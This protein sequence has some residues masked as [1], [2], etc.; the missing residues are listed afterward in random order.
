ML[1]RDIMTRDV[2]T[3]QPGTPVEEIARLLLAHRISGVPVVDPDGRVVG[4]VTEA[5]LIVRERPEGARSRWLRWFG[6]PD[7]MAAAYVKSHG[8]R[9]EE[10]MSRPAICVGDDAPIEAIAAL[11][12]DRQINRVPVLREGRLVGIVSREDLV[13]ALVARPA[14]RL[15]PSD[16][17]ELKR[18]VLAQLKGEAWVRITGLWLTVE[19][20]EV[21]IWGLVDSDPVRD[22]VSVAI[23]NVPG[24]RKVVNRLTSR[25]G[26]PAFAA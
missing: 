24:V 5:D 17:Q 4:L 7:A 23:E 2:I 6:D 15:A 20:G 11:L 3:V 21:E 8:V 9:A 14:L 19:K 16:D 12:E 22:A 1:A 13:K 25:S 18:R 26:L 10:I